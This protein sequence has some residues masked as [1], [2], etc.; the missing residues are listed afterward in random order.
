MDYIFFFSIC[1]KILE[2]IPDIVNDMLKGL[3]SYVPP[4][5]IDFCLSF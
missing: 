3:G 1:L 4:K 5:N 2:S